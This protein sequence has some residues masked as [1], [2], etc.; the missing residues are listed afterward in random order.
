MLKAKR[1]LKQSYKQDLDFIVSTLGFVDTTLLIHTIATILQKILGD[2]DVLELRSI[3]IIIND[4]FS[5]RFNFE[6]EEYEDKE[7]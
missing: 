7:K 4:F 6:K 2:R 5:R 3:E 1:I